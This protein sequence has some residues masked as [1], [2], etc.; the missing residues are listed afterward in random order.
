MNQKSRLLVFLPLIFIVIMTSGCMGAIMRNSAIGDAKTY[1]ELSPTLPAIPNGKGRVFI[2]MTDGGPSVFNTMGIVAQSLTIDNTVQFISG[3][4]YFYADLG[5]GEHSVTSE[6]VI[7]GLIKR[8]TQKGENAIDF[9]LLDQEVKY[10]RIDFKGVGSNPKFGSFHPS[11]PES[12]E[13]A[14]TE[15]S[16]L[17]FYENHN[18]GMHT[19]RILQVGETF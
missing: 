11:L 12:N 4:T 15:I 18:Y 14:E 3:E 2:Y 7:S 19:D 16:D 10:I 1:A 9:K 17:K 6:K 5:A 8:T 13:K